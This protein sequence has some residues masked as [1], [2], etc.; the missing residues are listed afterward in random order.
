MRNFFTIGLPSKGRLKE[1]AISFFNDRGH[2]ILLSKK[3]RNYFLWYIVLQIPT[4]DSITID[5]QI[6]L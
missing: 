2:K 1:K 5:F 3:E 4:N 6:F